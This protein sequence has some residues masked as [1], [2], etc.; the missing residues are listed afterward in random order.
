MKKTIK[1][2]LILFIFFFF[3]GIAS[4]SNDDMLSNESNIK[5]NIVYTKYHANEL[6]KDLDENAINTQKKYNNQY[7]EITGELST[8]DSDGDYFCIDRTDEKISFSNIQCYIRNDEQLD[9]I[10]SLKQG[11]KITVKG[12]ITDVG[13]VLGY[14]LDLYEIVK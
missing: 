3:I 10:S 2:I 5:E 14:S 9:I 1:I 12:K 6:M 4:D 13:E 11:N 8:L 7:V